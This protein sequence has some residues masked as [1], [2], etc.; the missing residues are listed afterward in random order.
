MRRP[1]WQVYQKIV[2]NRNAEHT[3]H[4]L[5]NKGDYKNENPGESLYRKCFKKAFNKKRS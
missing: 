1:F 5:I 2:G 3:V 4:F